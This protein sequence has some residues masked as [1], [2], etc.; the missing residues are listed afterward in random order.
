M[1]SPT[2]VAA[3]GTLLLLAPSPASTSSPAAPTLEPAAPQRAA[4]QQA[5]ALAVLPPPPAPFA[6]PGDSGS[7]ERLLVEL[8]EATGVHL[9][10]DS[11]ARELLSARR[12]A[13]EPAADVAP[14][15]AWSTI[16]S[17]LYVNDIALYELRATEPRLLLVT[18]SPTGANARQGTLRT[19]L[20]HRVVAQSDLPR[21]VEH[22]ALR[23][24][25]ALVFE[26]LDTRQAA[27]AM[28]GMLTQDTDLI[29]PD[30][31][32]MIVRG[33]ASHVAEL[34]ELLAEMDRAA[35]ARAAAFRAEQEAAQA[36][37]RS[38]GRAQGDG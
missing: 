24:Q 15:Q 19:G 34:A 11:E 30:G 28:R 13:P 10:F 5:E 1:H 27:N 32:S 22:H 17:L 31:N 36:A 21:Y 12:I 9:V 14:D 4:A 35:A 20:P 6:V 38:A 16:E 29:P 23:I 25:S 33:R 26:A 18:P 2:L 7:L 37:E 8:A 3:V